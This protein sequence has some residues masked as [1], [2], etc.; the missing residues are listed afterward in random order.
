MVRDFE[1]HSFL[2]RLIRADTAG[3]LGVLGCLALLWLPTPLVAQDVELDAEADTSQSTEDRSWIVTDSIEVEDRSPEGSLL[4]R[5]SSTATRTR[6]P[7]EEIPQSIQVLNR[8]LL[9]EQDVQGLDDALVNVSGVQPSKSLELVLQQPIVRG[10]AAEV[11][12]DGLPAFNLTPVV[13][14]TTVINV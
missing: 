7:I 1:S 8:T 10:F 6:T 5:M 9:E 12:L 14:P 11:F 3:C 4:E 2:R 13:D